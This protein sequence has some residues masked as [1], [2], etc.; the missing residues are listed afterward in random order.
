MKRIMLIV[1]ILYCISPDLFAGPIDDIFILLGS[2][3][4][5]AAPRDR[6]PKFRKMYEK[7]YRGY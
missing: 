2:L 4:C 6:D 3:A 5:S 1:A 7:M